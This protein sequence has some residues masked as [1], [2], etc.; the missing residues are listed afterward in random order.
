VLVARP[1][2]GTTNAK[3]G[4]T[5]TVTAPVT[6]LIVT[7]ADPL[8]DASAWLVAVTS[9]GF[10]PGTLAGA[11]KST[12]PALAPLGATHGFD[13][14]TQICPTLAF[15]FTTPATDHVTLASDVFVTV[16]ENEARCAAPTVAVGGATLTVTPLVIVTVAAAVTG[17]PAGC[18]LTAA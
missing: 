6:P 17:P 16:A 10:T 3:E 8:F 4:F 13:S 12:L 5:S 15:P 7:V 9:S 1:D 11:R 18:G 2:D 14:L